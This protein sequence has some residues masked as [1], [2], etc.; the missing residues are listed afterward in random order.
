MY[1]RIRI[2]FSSQIKYI[3]L[4]L[5]LQIVKAFVL[6]AMEKQMKA[7][8]VLEEVGANLDLVRR[9]KLRILQQNSERFQAF[10]YPVEILTQ[11]YHLVRGY[12]YLKIGSERTKQSALKEFLC[13]LNS[14]HHHE[15]NLYDA[16]IEKECLTRI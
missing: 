10:H 11:K 5:R 8:T 1:N 3:D 4:H 16:R 12:W 14:Q 9:G 7:A 13:C 6:I 15:H 2:G